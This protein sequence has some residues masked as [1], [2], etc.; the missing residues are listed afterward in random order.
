[1]AILTSSW[2]EPGS[3]SRACRPHLIAQNSTFTPNVSCIFGERGISHSAGDD[4]EFSTARDHLP[5]IRTQQ[6][7]FYIAF[8]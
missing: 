2:S 6:L 1:M 7:D 8:T 4:P 3:V 5:H